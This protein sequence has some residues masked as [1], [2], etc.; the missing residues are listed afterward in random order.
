MTL[1]PPVPRTVPGHRMPIAD[2]W[3]ADHLHFY[4]T[5]MVVCI[6]IQNDPLMDWGGTRV[7]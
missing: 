7:S 1:T 4:L 3:G 6:I 5:V 2:V